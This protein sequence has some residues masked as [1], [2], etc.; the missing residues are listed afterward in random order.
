MKAAP[1]SPLPPPP[2]TSDLIPGTEDPS[3]R[4]IAIHL[5]GNA[6]V[7]Y[8]LIAWFKIALSKCHIHI[9]NCENPFWLLGSNYKQS[10]FLKKNL[11]RRPQVECVKDSSGEASLVTG[12]INQSLS[13]GDYAKCIN[14]KATIKMELLM[15]P[16]IKSSFKL[17]HLGLRVQN[18]ISLSQRSLPFP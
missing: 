5:N 7:L 13:T 3:R 11:Q 4:Q 2:S 18:I 12:W 6:G 17:T 10:D 9:S 8:T 14:C 1:H 16:S 15:H